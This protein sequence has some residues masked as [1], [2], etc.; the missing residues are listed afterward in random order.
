[1]P[2]ANGD[3]MHVHVWHITL[4]AAGSSNRSSRSTASLRSNGFNSKHGGS[5]SEIRERPPWSEAIA[6]D[7]LTF[8]EKI[9]SDF[10]T[11]GIH[12]E[13]E[14]AGGMHVLR[15]SSD[16]YNGEFAQKTEARKP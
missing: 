9:K 12:R 14:Q 13:V 16:V 5:K 6:V 11:K 3:F 1:M 15:E 8:A 7:S 2:H 4:Q 10:G